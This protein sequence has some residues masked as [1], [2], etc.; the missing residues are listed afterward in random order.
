MLSKMGLRHYE[1]HVSRQSRDRYG[2]DQTFFQLTGN[3]V[4][5][6]FHAARV[7]AQRMNDKRDLVNFPEQAVRA[8]QINAM[9]LI[10]EISHLMVDSYRQQVNPNIMRDALLAIDTEFGRG[11]VDMVIERFADDFPALTVYRREQTTADWLQ[12]Q[13]GDTPNREIALEEMLMLWLSN[14]NPAFSPFMELFDDHRL[15]KVTVYPQIF[16]VLHSF[17]AG[18]PGF[19]ADG[20]NLIDVLRAPALAAPHSLTAQLEFIR[21]NW[22]FALSKLLYRLLGSLDLI[23]EEE[24]VT[25]VGGGP[26]PSEVYEFGGMAGDPERYTMDR[27]WMPRLVLIAKN[28]YVWLDQLSR[29]YGRDISRLDEVPD[30]ELDR[31]ARF[32]FTGLWLIGLWERSHASKRIKQLTGNPEAVASAYSLL[33]YRIADDLGGEA[34]VSNLRQRAWDRGIRLASDMVPNHMGIDAN[35]VMDHPDW[36]IS[37]P[38]SPFPSDSFN[39]PNLTWNDRMG[40]YLEDHYFDRTDAAVVFKLVD[41]SNGHTRYVYHGNDGTSMPWNDTA[42]LNYLMPEVREAVIQTILN[43]ARQFPVIR[44]DAAMTLAKRHIQRLWF[45]EP[46][47]GGAIA[48]RADFGMTKQ[49]LD[50]LMPQE[51][52]REVVGRAAVEAPDPLLLA[53]AFWMLEGYFVRTLGMHRVYN[54]A[55]MNMIR[56]EE[57]A[58]YRTLIKNTLDFDPEI[59][60]RYVNF[61]NNPDER[62]AVDQFGKGDK[63]FGVCTLMVTL[64]GLPMFGHGQVEGYA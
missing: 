20:Q 54:S 19:G 8:G 35:W 63:Y 58:K 28:A 64:P 43:V 11:A 45:P 49:Q 7:F 39:G 37:A 55:F 44:F 29:Q 34:A 47:T 48:S 6:N 57:N 22:G 18:Q 59:L 30:E 60:K 31:L 51:F 16:P 12:G 15:E 36:F 17:F 24:K 3:V 40:I 25:F 10:D 53:E 5:A 26:G 42:Q 21:H 38:Y 27:E 61:M 14:L 62:T 23:Q 41:H 32:G 50:A 33:D 56:D 2:F 1:F 46:G 4:F 9:G 13:T 52:W